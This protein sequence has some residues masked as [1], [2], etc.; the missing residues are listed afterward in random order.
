MS[1]S[2][3]RRDF[4]SQASAAVGAVALAPTLHRVA[5]AGQV[6]ASSAADTVTLGRTGI[7]T[8]LLGI[9]TGFNGGNHSSAHVRMGQAAFTK[10]LRHAI[11]R[12]IRYIDTAD[13]Y[14]SHI[15]I[16]EAL[17]GVDRSK[18]FIQTKTLATHPAVA[19]A[20][21]DRFREEL[22]MDRLDSLL[23][24]C[25]QKGTWR[26]DM[27]PVMDVLSEAKAKGKVR[28][29]GI[30]CHGLDPLLAAAEADWPDV[31]FARINPFGS[32]MDAPPGKPVSVDQV[33]FLLRKIRGR[34]KG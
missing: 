12:G 23:L 17:K 25:M 3:S 1:N 20:D 8:S 27:R 29:V 19:K 15:F 18:L 26:I 7:E 9:G 4:L 30:S 33:V 21:I 6:A 2:F 16:R 34:G 13:M 28:A 22:G 32:A 5:S 31:Q 14:G 10:L 24:H 11:D